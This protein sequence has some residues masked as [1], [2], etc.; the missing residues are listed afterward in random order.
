MIGQYVSEKSLYLF[1]HDMY[2]KYKLY[3]NYN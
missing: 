2:T 1:I 3:T